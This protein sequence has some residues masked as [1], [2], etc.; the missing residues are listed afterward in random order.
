MGMFRQLAFVADGR[1]GVDRARL[2]RHQTLRLRTRRRPVRRP[3]RPPAIARFSTGFTSRSTSAPSSRCCSRPGCWNGMGR[4]GPSVCRACSWRWP[5]WCSGL[6]ETVS[7][8][9]RRA[10]KPLSR[11]LAQWP[12]HQGDVETAAALYLRGDVLGARSIRR[13]RHGFSNRRTWTGNFLGF[14]WLP[15]QIQSL[16]SV[17]VLTF[18]PIFA[19][20]RLSDGETGCGNSHPCARSALGLFIMVGSFALVAADPAVDRCRRTAEHLPGRSSPSHFSPSAEVM[21]SIVALEYAYTQ[22]PKTMKS[23]LMCFY[24]GAVAIGK[25]LRRGSEPFHPDTERGWPNNLK[26]RLLELP[27]DWRKDPRTVSL[28]GYDGAHRHPGRSDPAPRGRR[29]DGAGDSQASRRSIEAA[30]LVEGLTEA[31]GG[32]FPAEAAV[33]VRSWQTSAIRG[34][35]AKSAIRSSTPP[36]PG[37]ISDGPDRKAGH[38]SGTSA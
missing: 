30:A 3:Q 37:L 8:T 33:A 11:E 24:L 5:R 35:I 32:K 28:P 31:N 16:N 1:A 26:L 2:R 34:A 23:L 7:S 27:A 12:R 19:Y 10:A 29:A 22:A 14:E 17:F 25:F 9:C 38:P 36:A 21:V 15:S 18:I 13:A 20:R 6:A 4:T